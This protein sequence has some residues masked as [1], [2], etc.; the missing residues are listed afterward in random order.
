M[1]QGGEVEQQVGS[2]FVNARVAFLE[3]RAPDLLGLLADFCSAKFGVG[4]QLDAIGARRLLASAVD[5]NALERRQRLVRDFAFADAVEEAAAL[6]GVAGRA[7]RR[8]DCQQSVAVAVEPQGNDALSVAR[9]RPLMPQLA[10]RTAPKVQLAATESER[11]S[12]SIRICEH[13]DLAAGGVLDHDRHEAAIV[14]SDL[15]QRLP[16]SGAVRRVRGLGDGIARSSQ[17][18]RAAARLRARR[19]RS[20]ASSQIASSRASTTP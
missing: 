8:N 10:S 6:A 18:A 1:Q 13:Q 16:A 17:A 20:D 19:R 11:D 15:G 4:K 3:D 5:E 12:F 9:C 14:V 7:G 2:L